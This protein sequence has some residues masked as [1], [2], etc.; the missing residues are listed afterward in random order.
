MLSAT[1][2]WFVLFCFSLL[3]LLFSVRFWVSLPHFFEWSFVLC[4][5]LALLVFVFSIFRLSCVFFSFSGFVCVCVCVV[6]LQFFLSLVC[7]NNVTSSKESTYRG[8]YK[9]F[10]SIRF[11]FFCVWEKAFFY[12]L[13]RSSF[14]CL[15]H[16]LVRLVIHIYKIY[17]NSCLPPR[18]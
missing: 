4:Y 17:F 11:C 6:L 8:Q 15:F 10:F 18:L 1:D 2:V 16:F 5:F 9:F 12:L 3:F 13:T 7:C 14:L